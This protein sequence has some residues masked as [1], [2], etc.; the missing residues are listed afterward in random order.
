MVWWNQLEDN[1]GSRSRCMLLVDGNREEVANRL[2]QL[3]DIPEK[4]VIDHSDRWM[5]YGKP[6]QREDDSWDNTPAKEAQ[7]D[8][9]AKLL[10]CADSTCK[11]N[12]SMFKLN[13]C[14]VA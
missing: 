4:V 10:P 9:L 14:F 13:T 1:Q 7:L 8:E 3:V 2:T 6:V 11:C 5:P 12:F